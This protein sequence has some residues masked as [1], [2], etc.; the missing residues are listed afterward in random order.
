M[1]AMG[2]TEKWNLAEGAVIKHM[3]YGLRVRVP[4]GEIGV[5]DRADIADRPIT[6][7]EWPVVG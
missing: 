2:K 3:P 4:T 7:E 5:V 6:E 1:E